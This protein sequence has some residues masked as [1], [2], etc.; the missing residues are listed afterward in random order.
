MKKRAVILVTLLGASLGLIT[1]L[2]LAWAAPHLMPDGLGTNISYSGTVWNGRVSG[3]D[4]IDVVQFKFSPKM[5]LKGGLPLSFQTSSQA[6]QMSGQASRNQIVG[7]NFSG[8]L[9]N[10]PTRDGRL[11][12][13]NGVVNVQISELKFSKKCKSIAGNA[14]TDFLSRNKGRWQWKGPI[15]SGPLS[16]ENGDLIAKLSGT[17]NGQT[18]KADLRI[19]PNGTYRAD[20]SVQTSQP[21]AAIVLPLYG[22]EKRSG[23]FLLTEQG[24]WR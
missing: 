1:K 9:A 5:M 18:I 14:N 11:K 13:L 2:P 17:E 6:M 8:Q 15:L 16:C 4:Y 20:F 23:E 19:V 3:L 12:E 7:L 24:K 22:F 10:L 21:E